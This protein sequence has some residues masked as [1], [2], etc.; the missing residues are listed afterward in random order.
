MDAVYSSET[1]VIIYHTI[2]LLATART[3]NLIHY[4]V[5]KNLPLV[6]IL[7]QMNGIHTLPVYH[8]PIH[9]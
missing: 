7:S 8:L 4:P 1:L 5:H 9:V 3:P 6:P 2:P